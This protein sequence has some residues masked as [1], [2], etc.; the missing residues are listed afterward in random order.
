MLVKEALDDFVE[1]TT[2][3]WEERFRGT[4]ELINKLVQETVVYLFLGLFLGFFNDDGARLSLKVFFL[5]FLFFFG[6]D[7]I[8]GF[9]LGL[10]LVDGG[11][12]GLG[13][14][15][16]GLDRALQVNR[17][18]ARILFGIKITI[19]FFNKSFFCFIRLLNLALIFSEFTYASVL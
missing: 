2:E 12:F 13:L 3:N 16:S 9:G 8:L 6:I 15:I 7:V 1:V 14:S 5:S 19:K 10:R 17:R 11:L 18:E 4:Q